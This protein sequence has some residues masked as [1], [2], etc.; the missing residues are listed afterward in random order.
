MILQFPDYDTL[1]LALTSGVAPATTSLTSVTAGVDESGRPWIDAEVDA[2]VVTELKKFGVIQVTTRPSDGESLGNWLQALPLLREEKPAEI[3]GSR[4]V[5][6]ELPETASLPEVVGEMLRLSVDRQSFRWLDSGAVMLRVIGPPYYTL[7]RA[8]DRDS[9]TGVRAYVEQAPR[10]WAEIGYTHPLIKSITPPEGQALFLR[11]PRG[12]LFVAEAPFRDIYEILDFKLPRA[13]LAWEAA[14]LR[15]KLIVPLRLVEGDRQD[16]ELWVLRDDPV[17]RLDA[18]VRDAREGLVQRLIF[19]VGEREGK[20]VVVLRVRPSKQPPPQLVLEAEAYCLY[21]KLDNLFVPC[22]TKVHPQLRRDAV[23]KLLADDP[24]QVNWLR[25][26]PARRGA[27]VPERLPDAAFRPLVDWVDYVLDHDRQALSHWVE[28]FKFDFDPFVCPEEEAPRPR[29]LRRR[30]PSHRGDAERP[31][32]PANPAP[33]PKSEA[34]PTEPADDFDEIAASPPPKLQVELNQL[35]ERFLALEGPLDEPARLRLWPE[36]A[37]RHAALKHGADAALCW[38]NLLWEVLDLDAELADLR[39]EPDAPRREA[40]KARWE[41]LHELVKQMGGEAELARRWLRSE[42]AFSRSRVTAADFD[43]LLINEQPPFSEVRGFIACLVCGAYD[44]AAAKVILHRLP[45]VQQYLERHE[46]SVGLRP[47]WLAWHALARLSRDALALARVRDRLLARLVSEGYSAERDLPSFLRTAGLLDGDRIRAVQEQLG[48]LHEE[49]LQWCAESKGVDKA[50]VKETSGHYVDLIFAF[51]F[52][53]IGEP[54]R[55]RELVRAAEAVVSAIVARRGQR[56]EA[57]QAAEI[58]DFLFRAYRYR[59]EQA[60][61]GKPH[62]GPLPAELHELLDRTL[63]NEVINTSRLVVERRRDDSR[64]LEPQERVE[65]YGNYLRKRDVEFDRQLVALPRVREPRELRA[66][67]RDLLRSAGSRLNAAEDTVAVLIDALVLSPRVGESFA[68][69]LLALI[70]PSLDRLPTGRSEATRL[71]APQALLLERAMAIAANY[72]RADVTQLLWPRFLELLHKSST[73]QTPV[74]EINRAFSQCLRSLRKLGLRDEI[75]RMMAPAERLVLGGKS[76]AAVRAAAGQQWHL[77]V[78]ELLHLAGGWLMF[79][80]REEANE[81][82]D[83]ARDLLFSPESRDYAD[84][85]RP[86]QYV[87]L[88]VAYA[89]ALGQ[90]P[91]D[92]ALERFAE[93]FRK[94]RRLADGATPSRYYSRSHLSIIEAVVLAVVSEEFAMGPSARRW[95]DDDEYL[96]RRR[97]HRDHRVMLAKS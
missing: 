44:P 59:I 54:G 60:L 2:K 62:A 64:I 24:A 96:I 80:R 78:T 70:E 13:K 63:V 69:E 89:H 41:Q 47:V 27:F 42:D 10:V 4:E 75:A 20:P 35:Q 11:Q 66:T 15:K 77:T 17:M 38:M 36:M 97:I 55:A 43:K 87:A 5:I 94:M 12:W 51:G 58:H 37:L 40:R 91:I 9:A 71:L 79:G 26:D 65:V 6:F 32:R 74:P 34:S 21:L 82:L 14:E 92:L 49:A 56:D 81:A 45:R 23:R 48:R 84:G 18:L 61:A 95:M 1:K 19:A 30:T 50:S 73:W 29:A 8:I 86:P 46:R 72:G 52:A 22:G 88:A 53:R 31:L 16:P 67:V 39:R 25:P 57:P 68:S 3:G 76:V 85:L 33:E 90:A 83:A 7:L 28:E 93:L